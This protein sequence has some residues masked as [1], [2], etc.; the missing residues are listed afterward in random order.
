MQSSQKAAQGHSRS[1]WGRRVRGRKGPQL[2]Q[3]PQLSWSA[4]QSIMQ[5]AHPR[6]QVPLLCTHPAPPP[7]LP[8]PTCQGARKE[9]L[10]EEEEVLS[11]GGG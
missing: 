4:R 8:C 9:V 7:T 10:L 3:G 2:S 5:V 1:A 11:F 6:S